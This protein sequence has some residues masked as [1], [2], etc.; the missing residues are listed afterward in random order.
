[1]YNTYLCSFVRE[2][3]LTLLLSSP[4]GIDLFTVW[5]KRWLARMLLA[6]SLAEDVYLPVARSRWHKQKYGVRYQQNFHPSTILFQFS[7]YNKINNISTDTTTLI[8]AVP[9]APYL[10]LRTV[11]HTHKNVR[12]LLRAEYNE[13]FD[14]IRDT[15]PEFMHRV[16]SLSS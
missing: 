15:A 4:A 12:L 1:M 5:R 2:S 13:L 6:L 16:T 11:T 14:V 7:S 10:C 8:F 3:N 9:W